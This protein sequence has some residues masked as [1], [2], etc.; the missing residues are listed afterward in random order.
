MCKRRHRHIEGLSQ[1]LRA[2]PVVE[3]RKS[4]KNGDKLRGWFGVSVQLN[5]SSGLPRLISSSIALLDQSHRIVTGTTSICYNNF[6]AT[7]GWHPLLNFFIYLSNSIEEL[8][9]VSSCSRWCDRASL[10]VETK[11]EAF[12]SRRRCPLL[13]QYHRKSFSVRQKFISSSPSRGDTSQAGFFLISLCKIRIHCAKV[14][15]SIFLFWDS[16][17]SMCSMIGRF[18]RLQ[19][20]SLWASRRNT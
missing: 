14:Y 10:M 1:S 3:A 4:V 7:S 16:I 9:Y 19:R 15:S 20:S 13:F 5:L 18:V 17:E 8:K 6:E 2:T 11:Q 12:S